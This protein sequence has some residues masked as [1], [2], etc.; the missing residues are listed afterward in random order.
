MHYTKGA[1]LTLAELDVLGDDALLL[2]WE[3]GREDYEEA[4]IVR[5]GTERDSFSD[6]YYRVHLW[7]PDCAYYNMKERPASV[8]AE[9]RAEVDDWWNTLTTEQKRDAKNL[10][11]AFCEP[12]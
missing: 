8:E 10:W 3:E 12:L 9:A 6:S 11:A 1:R 4:V 2:M 5:V 7:Y